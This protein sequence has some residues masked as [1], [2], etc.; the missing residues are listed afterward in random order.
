M[1]KLK[2]K[3]EALIRMKMLGLHEN[4]IAEFKKGETVNVSENN[5][6]LY[7]LEDEKEKKWVKDWQDRTG[8]LVYHIIRT[9]DK[10][11]DILYVSKYE[12]EWE[13]E[14]NQIEEN[15]IFSYCRNLKIQEFS[16]YGIIGVIRAF[17]GLV[18]IY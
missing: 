13:I 14:K 18:R 1:G 7:W 2:Q 8:N 11:L 17:G 16:E 15:M 6:F 3:K 9:D 10:F 4:A 5:G 12:E